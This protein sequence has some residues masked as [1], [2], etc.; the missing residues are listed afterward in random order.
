MIPQVF[1]P[2]RPL[3]PYVE[4]IWDYRNLLAGDNVA[5]SILPDTASYLCFLY[6]DPLTTAHKGRLYTTRSGLAGFQSFRSDLGGLGKV[7]GV[8]ARLTPWGLNAFC[9]GIVPD[10]AE[11]R[12]DCRDIFPRYRI[13]ALEDGLSAAQ[14]ADARVSLVERFLLSRLDPGRAD[15]P[16]QMACKALDRT[17]GNVSVAA[18]ARKLGMT[19][20][21]LERRFL[22]HVGAAPKKYARIVRLRNAILLRGRL[23]GWADVACAAGYCDQSHL[24]RD[25]QALYGLSPEAL[26]PRIALSRTIRFSGLLNLYPDAE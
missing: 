7:S 5:L 14:N 3:Q 2:C 21:T 25:C 4:A 23:A 22:A 12:V 11:R 10:C 20:R 17:C 15:L 19:E 24:I 18:L 6:A 16:M 9:G 26:Y 13:E 8:S 1:R